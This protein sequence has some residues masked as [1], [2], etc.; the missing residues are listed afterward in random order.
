MNPLITWQRRFADHLLA[1]GGA[2]MPRLIAPGGD[3]AARLAVYTDGYRLR[4]KEALAQDFT[5]LAA[6]LGP[7]RF[8]RL[9][10]DYIHAHPSHHYN[11][12]WVGRSMVRHLAQTPP[13]NRN[14]LARELAEFEW[15]QGLCF[16]APDA[17]IATAAELTALPAAA[18]PR[19]RLRLQ[20]ALQRR[21]LHWNVD[22]LW[23]AA[24]AGRPLPPP[25]YRPSP[26]RWL[27]WRR[28]CR[29]YLARLEPDAAAAL[30]S[31][32]TGGDFAALCLTLRR[33]HRPEAVPARAVGLLKGWLEEGLLSAVLTG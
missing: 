7:Q 19:L 21:D 27:F 10:D 16:D 29:N 2:A 33:R 11:I 8:E 18:W 28:D 26:V 24:Q 5:L 4:L 1:G 25:A 6:W 9:L 15:A 12:R 3:A 30:D 31:I 32:R 22:E 17:P 20:P 23:A 13:W 14:T